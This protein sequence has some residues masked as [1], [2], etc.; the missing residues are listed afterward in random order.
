MEPPLIVHVI[1][2]TAKLG[3]SLGEGRVLVDELIAVVVV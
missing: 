2:E 1:D 3:L